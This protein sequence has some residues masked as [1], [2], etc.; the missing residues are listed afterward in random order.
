MISLY[1][2][3]LWGNAGRRA[4]GGNPINQAPVEA[5][6]PEF[7]GFLKP[8]PPHNG[9]APPVGMGRCIARGCSGTCWGVESV[10]LASKR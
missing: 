9:K 8:L 10:V 7:E 5:M 4:I 2:S 6:G 1:H 3:A